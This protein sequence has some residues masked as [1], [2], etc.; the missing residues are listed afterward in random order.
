MGVGF[1]IKVILFNKM[2]NLFCYG[3]STIK[4]MGLKCL[5]FCFSEREHVTTSKLVMLLMV[6]YFGFLKVLFKGHIKHKSKLNKKPRRIPIESLNILK[7]TFEKNR[8]PTTNE[9]MSIALEAHITLEQVN[10]WFNERRRVQKRNES[11]KKLFCKCLE[12][13]N[14]SLKNNNI[15]QKSFETNIYLESASEL[16]RLKEET[17]LSEL[18]IKKWFKNRRYR[19]TKKGH[20]V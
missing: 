3:G 18:K 4:N 17:N 11:C 15:L 8:K 9:K 1:I 20:K 2:C 14:I 6:N 10:S 5:K 19:L 7:R 16:Q 13:K 12:K